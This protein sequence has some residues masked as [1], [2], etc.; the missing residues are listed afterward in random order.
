MTTKLLF[1]RD[2]QGYNAFAPAFAQD[3]FSA[4]LDSGGGTDSITVPGNFQNWIVA[5]SYQPGSDIWV[6]VNASAAAPAGITFAAT[7][8][9]LNPASRTV[10]AGDEISVL[11]N[12]S[13][14]ADV[15]IVLYAI[16]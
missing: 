3:A 7:V 14:D 11:N 16:S 13:A 4:T 9:E 2:V 8:S 1:G 15:G 12:G 5:F 10:Q 6:A